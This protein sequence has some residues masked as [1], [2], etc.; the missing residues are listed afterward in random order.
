[1]EIMTDITGS[2]RCHRL[3]SVCVSVFFIHNKE[4]KRKNISDNKLSY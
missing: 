4:Y 2:G 3:K 1:M